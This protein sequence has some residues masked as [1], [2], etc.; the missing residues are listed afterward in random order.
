MHQ[1]FDEM[2]DIMDS[3]F[4]DFEAAVPSPVRVE[5]EVGWVFRYEEQDP[6]QAIV[7]K[8]SLVQSGLRAAQILLRNGY[9]YEQAMLERVVDEANEDILFLVHAVAYSGPT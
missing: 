7:Q 2:L 1:L 5:K 8:L 4:R 6:L 3:A 9:I